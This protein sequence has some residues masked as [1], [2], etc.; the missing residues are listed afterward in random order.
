MVA[1]LLQKTQS[2][3]V[4][5]IPMKNYS[6]ADNIEFRTQNLPRGEDEKSV[7]DRV[8]M[9]YKRRNQNDLLLMMMDSVIIAVVS[10]I[11]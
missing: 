10:H 8:V 6:K 7:I 3:Q 11:F 5:V 2:P 4:V 1:Q 9:M